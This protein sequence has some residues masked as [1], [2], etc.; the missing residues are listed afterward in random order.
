MTPGYASRGGDAGVFADV[1]DLRRTA[2]QLGIA[3]GDLSRLAGQSRGNATSGALLRTAVF[4][5]GTAASAEGHLIEASVS[6]YL[7]V[8]QLGGEALYLVARADLFVLADAAATHIRHIA[9]DVLAVPV[10]LA[11][12]WYVADSIRANVLNSATQLLADVVTG[13]V[14][15]SQIDDRLRKLPG[16]I[17]KN[18]YGDVSALLSAFPEVTDTLTGGLPTAL[19]LDGPGGL[20][21]DDI[22]GLIGAVQGFAG[23]AGLGQDGTVHATKQGTTKGGQQDLASIIKGISSIEASRDHSGVKI[24]EVAGPPRA[25]IVEIPGTSE[26]SP[27]AGGNPSDLTQNAELMQR[28]GELLN[29]I[30]SAMD[31]A[32]IPPGEAIMLSGHSQGGIAAAALAA[33]IANDPRQHA[34]FNVTNVL[35]AGSPVAHFDIPPSVEVLSL[36]HR[37]DPVPRLDGDPNPDREHWQTLT[38]DVGSQDEIIDAHHGQRYAESA[39]GIDMRDIDDSFDRFLSG[40]ESRTTTFELSRNAPAGAGDTL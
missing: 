10:F 16:E 17:G 19:N 36:E 32:G 34:R 24:V 12:A 29:G 6:A 2:K 21:P 28:R 7:V 1:D 20:L 9:Q 33:E 26:W 14:P 22:E 11:T 8:A 35:T 3:A 31:Q 37:Q 39:S 5:P 18:V 15:P 30:R 38:W 40:H 25:W 13:R 4:S 23:I 27:Q